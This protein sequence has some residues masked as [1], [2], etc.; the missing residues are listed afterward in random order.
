MIEGLFVEDPNRFDVL[1]EVVK[2]S[3][4]LMQLIPEVGPLLS[5]LATLLAT[6]FNV[7]KN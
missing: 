3:V 1:R 6:D 4:G 2:G 5:A 7:R